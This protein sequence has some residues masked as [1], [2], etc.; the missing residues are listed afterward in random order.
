MK[1]TAF[2]LMGQTVLPNLLLQH[3]PKIGM[4]HEE[5]V[6]WIQLYARHQ[7]GEAFP[8]L[9][10]VAE[11]LQMDIQVV[12]QLLNQL[13]TKQLISIQAKRSDYGQLNDELSFELMYQKLEQLAT[14]L[15]QKA[16]QNQQGMHMSQLYRMFEEEFG[17]PLSSIEFQRIKQWV[18]E[19]HY[20]IELIELALKEAILNQVYNLNYIDRIL[21]AWEKKNIRTKEQVQAAQNDRQR[22]L[23]Q[24]ETNDPTPRELPKV[25]LHNWL[26]GE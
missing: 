26:E 25:T 11:D 5:F 7:K 23:M 24:K 2:Y 18:Q 9:K 17:R 19:D 1:L 21:L 14:Q 12:Y 10:E 13:I 20:T 8:D 16:T 6:L 15:E 4:Q 3:Y 22:H